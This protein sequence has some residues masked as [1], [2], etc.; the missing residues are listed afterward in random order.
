ML[1]N[2]WY[3]LLLSLFAGYFVLGGVDYGVGLLL[4][5]EP[6]PAQRRRAL[7]AIGPFFLPNE[8]WLVVALGV[9]FGAFP[10]IEGS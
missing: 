4:A 10:M 7:T 6:D 8:V 3:L 9:L 5:G 2:A 1:E